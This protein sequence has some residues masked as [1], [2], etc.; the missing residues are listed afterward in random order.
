MII[1][2]EREVFILDHGDAIF[3]DGER[4]KAWPPRR[5]PGLWRLDGGP[6]PR[7]LP[8]GTL[9]GPAVFIPLFLYQPVQSVAFVVIKR[10][11][12]QPVNPS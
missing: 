10:L 2:P 4:M 3:A 1:L 7:H 6:R 9:S 8:D 12:K 5:P 11:G